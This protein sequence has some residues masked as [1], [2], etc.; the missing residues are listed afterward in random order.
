MLPRRTKGD[1]VTAVLRLQW[2]D[3]ASLSGRWKDAD[4]L[5]AMMQSGT[6]SLSLQQFEDRLRQLDARM[7]LSADETGARLNLQVAKDKLDAALG[8]AVQ[9][10]KEPVFPADLY[11]ERKRSLV[12]SIQSRRDQ[13]E[14]LVADLL[15]RASHVYPESDPR[16]YRTPEEEIADLQAHSLGRMQDFYRDFAGASQGQFA[17]V[18]EIDP[19]AMKAWLESALG[20]WKSR[21]PYRRIER[22]FHPLKPGRTLISVPDKPN[23]VYLQTRA[24][25]LSEDDPDYPALA[26]ALRL[27]GGDA[28]SRVSKRLREQEGLSYGAYAALSADRKLPSAAITV[29]AIH[30]PA[31][32]PRLEVAL[33][34]E[35]SRA[36][37]EGFTQ[38]ELDAVRQAWA[39]RR[40]Q[41]L[42]DES[43]VASLL[44]SNLYWSDTMK[45]WTDFDDKIRSTT[46]DQ[47]NAAFRKYVRPDQ[48]LVLGAGQY[49]PTIN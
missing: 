36:L 13:P 49:G 9:A 46:L 37:R 31:V 7:D 8:L 29:R 44:A 14:A 3:L 33:E 35:L 43:N 6:R 11:E 4:M 47:V 16:H 39:Q 17:V 18:G 40:S 5:D 15:R 30:A 1:R 20:D 25:E 26:L 24:I 10:L 28:G 21:Q 34:E 42:T 48:A 45:R 32:L 23:A 27:F 38:A 12:N 22:P 2:G 19:A 41:A